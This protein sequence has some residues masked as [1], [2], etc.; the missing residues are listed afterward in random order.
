[1]DYGDGTAADL[2][3]A[4]EY[5]AWCRAWMTACSRLLTP[6]GSWWVLICHEWEAEFGMLLKHHVGLTIRS[7]VTWYE[8]FGKNCTNNFNRC[9]RRLFYCVKDPK[10]FVFNTEAVTRP[11]DRQTK[12]ADKRAEPGGKLWDDVW[13]IPRL[14]GTAT[15]RIPGFP[16]Q[17]PEALLEPIIG[18]SSD[19]GDLVLDPF[20]G[21]GTTGAVAIRLGRRYL[22]IEKI[23]HFAKLARLRLQGVS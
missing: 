15:E 11:S 18:C 7:W 8:T 22:G 10:Q 12:Y 6:D 5:L 3:P 19:P 23:P 14:P 2:L 21:S 9:S 13:Q 20:S 4:D 16:T 17:L 1:V